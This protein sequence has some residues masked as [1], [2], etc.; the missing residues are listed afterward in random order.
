MSSSLISLPTSQETQNVKS[1]D[2]RQLFVPKEG[3]SPEGAYL[4]GWGYRH[5]WGNYNGQGTYHLN[6]SAVKPGSLV[7]VSIGEGAHG[8]GKFIG[9]AR[10]TLHNVAPGDGVVS[11]WVNIE[12]GTPIRLYVDYLVI[13][14]NW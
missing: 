12:W 4:T 2:V 7:F 10:Y 5:D 8:G 14:P 13:D 3:I 11:I 6:W 1:E 9:S